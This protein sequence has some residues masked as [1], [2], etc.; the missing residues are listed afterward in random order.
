[1]PTN[2]P[3]HGKKVREIDVGDLPTRYARG[4]HCL[5]LA[6][7]FRD[8]KPHSVKAF[9]TKLV[10]WADG[11]GELKV[12][13]AYCRHLGGDLSMGE[14]KNGDIACPFHDWRW[15]GNGKCT[16]IPY[17]RRVPLLARTRPWLT[18]ERNGQLFVWYD[19]EGNRPAPEV[20]IPRIQ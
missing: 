13:D 3:Q 8:G 20:T 4:W 16:E 6:E 1:M 15:N 2:P 17:A 10:V 12:L 18:L 5:G 9:G 19:H 7:T 14:I 11:T